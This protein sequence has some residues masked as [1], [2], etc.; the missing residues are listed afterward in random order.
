MN[1]DRTVL[2]D[3]MRA[4][5][6]RML[7][8]RKSDPGVTAADSRLS[9]EA[10]LWRTRTGSPW[11]DLPERFG[12]WN[13]VFKRFRRWVLAGVFKALPERFHLEYVFVDGTAVQAHRKAAGAKGGPA[14]REPAAP[15]AA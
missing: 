14:D 3:A 13:S 10:V 8:G 7:P 11:R 2:T 9:V 6:E 15:E 12:N 1:D 5:I 4:R